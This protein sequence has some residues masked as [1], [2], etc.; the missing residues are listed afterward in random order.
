[1]NEIITISVNGQTQQVAA[2]TTVA[3]LLAA[4]GIDT[5]HVAVEYNGTILKRD[6]F[7]S[8]AIAAAACL[9][10]VHFVGGG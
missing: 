7:A 3:E 9:E 5:A 6:E 4:A 8:T 1:M 2:A 10:I